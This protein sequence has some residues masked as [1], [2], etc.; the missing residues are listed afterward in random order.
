MDNDGGIKCQISMVSNLKLNN[1]LVSEYGCKNY[2]TSTLTMH[3][4]S[5]EL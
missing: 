1:P 5:G 2:R 3:E 4:K